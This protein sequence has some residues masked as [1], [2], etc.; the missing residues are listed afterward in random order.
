MS[1]LWNWSTL[2]TC[3]LSRSWH[4][5]SASAFAGSCIGILLLVIALEG[6][7]RLATDYDTRLQHRCAQ[8]AREAVAGDDDDAGESTR[9]HY[10]QTAAKES[11]TTTTTTAAAVVAAAL[12]AQ[13]QQQRAA[14]VG[15]VF[16]PSV[17]EQGVRAGL[18]AA[19]LVGAYVVM[20]LAMSFNG[21]V[22]LCIVAGGFLGF[23]VFQWRPMQL[24]AAGRRTMMT[25][26][27]G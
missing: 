6:L 20:L 12:V 2:N 21:Y 14:Q 25:P 1:M 4:I 3:L 13:P 24:D 15:P 26:G 17:G 27:C 19:Q 22:L 10:H 16:R 9:P 23:A 5:T 7:R 8:R 11:A 18:H